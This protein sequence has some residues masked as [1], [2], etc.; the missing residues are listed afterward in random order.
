MYFLEKD[1]NITRAKELY[2]KASSVIKDKN[3]A[4]ALEERLTDLEE[5]E[6]V[7]DN[8]GTK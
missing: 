1:K 5:E 6:K 4:I 8:F 3:D 2:N 7:D